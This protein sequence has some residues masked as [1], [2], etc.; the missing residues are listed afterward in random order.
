MATQAR[1]PIYRPSAAYHPVWKEAAKSPQSTKNRTEGISS[2]T[3]SSVCSITGILKQTASCLFRRKQE[4]NDDSAS[5]PIHSSDTKDSAAVT[6]QPARASS[7]LAAGAEVSSVH[8]HTASFT[9]T[10]EQQYVTTV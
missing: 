8:K 10:I 7:Q 3:T 1:P 5:R 2:Q 6:C 4:T 9:H